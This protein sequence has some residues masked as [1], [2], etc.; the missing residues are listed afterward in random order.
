MAITKNLF[1]ILAVVFLLVAFRQSP[2]QE[3][4]KAQA[5]S[6]KAKELVNRFFNEVAGNQHNVTLLEELLHPDFRSHHYPPTGSDKAGFIA[7]IKGTVAAFPDIQV[8][9]HDQF[10]EGDKVFTYFSWTGTHKGVFNGVAP[11]GKQ[12][13]VEGM[14]IWR[15]EGG[16]IRENWVV[17]DI[18]GLMTQLGVVPPPPAK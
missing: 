3:M 15:I 13:K 14:D 6:A 10:V 17:M 8:A 18:M 16:K 11:T 7:A 5:S 1:S 2:A 12:V 9:I 4:Q